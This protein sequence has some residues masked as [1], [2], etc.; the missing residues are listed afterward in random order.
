M[1]GAFACGIVGA[2]DEGSPCF[3]FDFGGGMFD[4]V[5]V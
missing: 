2:I 4:V 5:F 3:I 1:V